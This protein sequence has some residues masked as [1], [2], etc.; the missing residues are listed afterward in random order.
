MSNGTDK[1][2]NF[3]QARPLLIVGNLIFAILLAIIVS[4]FDSMSVRGGGFSV[5]A[6]PSNG[7]SEQLDSNGDP[8][9]GS[10][11]IRVATDTP[12]PTIPIVEAESAEESS[13]STASNE[14]ES[15]PP[16]IDGQDEILPAVTATPAVCEPPPATWFAYLVQ[17]GDLLGE[18]A[19]RSGSSI[20]ELQQVNCLPS[21]TI[22]Y[23]T[24]LYVPN[25][26]KS[27]ANQNVTP[28][29]VNCEAAPADWL[30]YIVQP[31]DNV[32]RISLGSGVSRQDLVK[33]N[34]LA[35]ESALQAGQIIYLPPGSTYLSNSSAGN[36]P[37]AVP[38]TATA[39]QIVQT[40]TST[41]TDTPIPTQTNTP[42]PTPTSTQEPER[43]VE[44]ATSVLPTRPGVTEIPTSIP[45][46]EPTSTQPP[47]D[48]PTE[49]PTA[50]VTPIPVDTPTDVPPPSPT[51]VPTEAPTIIP[52][53]TATPIPTE[54]PANTPTVEPTETIPP[55][56]TETLVPVDTPTAEL[57]V[58][59]NG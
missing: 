20:Q 3:L 11:I 34:C 54:P 1:E 19:A 51:L 27:E 14:D 26:I 49:I 25:E 5:Y 13:A 36:V 48:A 52:V 59:P 43:P 57:T 24:I 46:P 47:T 4:S 15:K 29:A 38:P 28:F 32:F 33:F 42:E 37:T 39:E 40:A 17:P 35:S 9:P 56:A 18:I 2:E 41:S 6:G 10:S 45:T 55:T 50:S 21:T 58:D 31:G 8:I 7:A 12:E 44:T 23:G 16:T 53:E 30:P 22:N